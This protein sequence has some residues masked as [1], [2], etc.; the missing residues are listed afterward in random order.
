L[1]TLT[2]QMAEEIK[3][4]SIVV[5]RAILTSI[6][7]SGILGFAMLVAY[8][9]CL[10]DLA[11]VLESQ[12]TLGYP[13]LFVAQSGTRSTAGAAVMALLI[14]ALGACSTVGILASSSRMLWSFARDRGI[15]FWRYFVKVPCFI[16]AIG[17]SKKKPLIV[18]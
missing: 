10:G 12:L 15:P 7:L 18:I 5:P 8:L 17:L 9:F 13:F 11:A 4:A 14:D 3:N 1:L 16:A 2:D 6:I